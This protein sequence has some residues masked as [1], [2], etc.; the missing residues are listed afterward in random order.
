MDD[1]L[2]ETY[3]LFESNNISFIELTKWQKTKEM[4]S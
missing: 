4:N 3:N 2:D 1:Y